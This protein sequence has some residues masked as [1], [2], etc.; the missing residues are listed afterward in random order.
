VRI[1]RHEVFVAL[2]E[3][4]VAAAETNQ[5]DGAQLARLLANSERLEGTQTPGDSTPLP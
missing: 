4:N 1:Q 3:A 2:G 5:D